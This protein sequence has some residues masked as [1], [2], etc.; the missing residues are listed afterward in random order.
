MLLILMLLFVLVPLAE[1]S[2]LVYIG[3][4]VGVLYTVLIVVAT[5]LVGAVLARYQGLATLSRVRTSLEQGILPAN[6]LFEGL[7][8]LVGGLLLLTPGVLTDAVG[9]A[10]L[11]PYTRRTVAGWVRRWLGRRMAKGEAGY[12]ELR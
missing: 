11:V 10:L 1:L 6:E 12:W 8:I 3:T 4:L 9:F 2:L 7:L 5:G